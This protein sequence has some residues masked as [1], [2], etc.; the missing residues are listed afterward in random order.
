MV[1]DEAVAIGAVIDDDNKV[2]TAGLIGQVWA[3]VRRRA[4]R[5]RTGE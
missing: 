4:R 2:E 3:V 5:G 1:V